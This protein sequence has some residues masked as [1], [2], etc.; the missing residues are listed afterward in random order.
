M[1]DAYK[2]RMIGLP[3]GEKP[4]KYVKPFSSNTGTSRT[5]RQTNGRKDGQNCYISISRVIVLTRDK[6]NGSMRYVGLRV[7]ILV[8]QKVQ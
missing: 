7:L 3:Y 6:K 2:T 5:D 4:M 8:Q 1:F